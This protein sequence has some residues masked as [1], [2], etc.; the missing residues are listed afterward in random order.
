LAERTRKMKQISVYASR[1]LIQ[2]HTDSKKKTDSGIIVPDTVKMTDTTG[3][4]KYIT[5]GTVLNVGH[6]CGFAT[7]GDTVLFNEKDSAEIELDEK[8]Y[9]IIRDAAIVLKYKEEE[10]TAIN[11]DRV[12]IEVDPMDKITKSGIIIPENANHEP[13]TGT[14]ILV[15][16]DCEEIKSNDRV[17]FGKSAGL[18]LE[19]RGKS[20]LCVRELDVIAELTE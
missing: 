9:R 15:G 1:V 10:I 17:L 20:Y 16:K 13:T 6:N 2:E 5:T 7:V 11:T 8:H 18:Y 4:H 12:L 14:V 19:F 3:F